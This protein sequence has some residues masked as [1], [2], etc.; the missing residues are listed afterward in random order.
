MSRYM[1][2]ASAKHS[3]SYD[4]NKLTSS[5]NG[6]GS[7]AYSYYANGN[8]KSDSRRD[9]QFRYDLLN[10]PAVVTDTTGQVIKAKYSYLADG[11]KLSVR[12]AQNDGLNYRG[13][14]IYTVDRSVGS[15]DVTEKLE[16]ISHDEGR[17]LA[18]SASA[19]V[20]T[21]QFIDTWH[22]RDHLGSIRTV[23]DITRDTS[24]VSNPT[25]AIL[26]QNDYLPFGTRVNITAQAYDPANRYRFNGKEE[27][28]TGSLGLTDYGARFYDCILP[29]WTTQ[30]PLAEKYY[31]TSPYVFCNNNPVNFVD[32]DGRKIRVASEYQEQFK[33]DLEAI[34][35]DKVELFSFE[36]EGLT[37]NVSKR[38]FMNGLNRDQKVLFR[39][40][41]KALADNIE[42]TVAYENNYSIEVDGEVK[43][44]DIVK[45]WGGALYDKDKQTI[46]VAPDI[47]T[48]DVYPDDFSSP[49]E[50]VQNT[51]SGLF[52]EIGER[53][54]SNE[55]IRGSVIIY[56]N[57]A[58]RILKLPERPYD[59]N[60]IN[61][62][63]P[64]PIN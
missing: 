58:R 24:E 54:E 43:N 18:L 36:D 10:L 14:F 30:D 57:Y 25:L 31:S 16:S 12:D 5:V 61:P 47:G 62:R 59:F 52:H 9:L 45:D 40:L 2:H 51:T 13:S 33:D 7:A 46:V 53:H 6:S 21:T 49:V 32:P 50:V 55:K 44:V 28:V 64:Y 63:T 56:E 42:T 48:V 19:G 1:P 37:L 39:G 17:F 38:D 29:R 11:T 27:Q 26:E 23:L 35:G 22:I 41:Y 8:L 4:G 15:T 20:T 3:F 34:F 60:H